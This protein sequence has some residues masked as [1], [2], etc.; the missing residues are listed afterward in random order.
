M[1]SAMQNPT[2]MLRVSRGMWMTIQERSKGTICA[3]IAGLVIVVLTPV[4]LHAQS[5]TVGLFH[6][7]SMASPGY[8][9]FTPGA[10]EDTYLID[11]WGRLINRWE[12]TYQPAFSVYLLE[13]GELLRTGKMTAGGGAGGR[14][15]KFS[16]DG[17]LIWDYQYFTADVLQHHDV[18]PLPNGNVLIL[19]WEDYSQADAIAAGRDPALL[20]PDEL[21]PEHIIEVEPTGLATGNIVWEW[22]LWDHLVQDFDSTKA[23]YGVVAEHPE[24][25]DINYTP[26]MAKDWIHAN[27]IDYNPEL[28]QIVISC[29]VFDEIWVIDHSTT[30]AEAAGHTGGNAGMGGDILYRWGNP[31]TYD[32]GDSTD[33]T[34][35]GQHDARW[36]PSGFAGEGN[37]LIFNNGRG[38]D[39]GDYST[40]D[41]IT[42]TVD[43]NGEYPQP[44]PGVS[45]GPANLTWIYGETPPTDWF[46]TNISGQQRLPNGNTLICSGPDGRFFEVTPDS[47]VVWRY[48]NPAN[49]DGIVIQGNPPGTNRTFR[50]T[51]IPADYPGLAGRDLTPGSAIEIYPIT[52]SGTAHSPLVPMAF[53]SVV[54]TAEVTSDNTITSVELYADLGAGFMAFDMYDDGNHHD[55]VAGD[56]VYGVAIPPTGMATTVPYYVNAQDDIASSVDDPPNPPSTVYWYSTSYAAPQIFI[57][58]VLASNSACCPDE[59]GDFDAWIELYNAE[60]VDVDLSGKYLSND[61]NDTTRF[62]IGDTTIPANGH[63][64]FWADNET[65]EGLAHTTFILNPTAGEIGLFDSDDHGRGVL[66]SLSYSDQTPDTSYGRTTDGSSTWT[67][68]PKPS[69]GSFNGECSCPNHADMNA[70]SFLDA[71]DLN[72][73]IS[74]LF[75]NGSDPQDPQCPAPRSDFDCS[76]ESDAVDL[77]ALINHLFFNG[78]APCDP[79]VE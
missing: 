21:S 49:R 78:N 50:C 13:N 38:R 64:L 57:N 73:I 44:P 46:A 31:V 52:I 41:E 40:V 11:M 45:H 72:A 36:V 6:Y 28:D 51:R 69:P 17:T 5:Q 60:A 1:T 3:L 20:P 10:T 68:F 23:N 16:W 53:D 27:S 48:I 30:T 74:A 14:I 55:G 8:N 56:D 25:V 9:L 32:A 47:Q 18:E 79:C 70:D 63:M 7:D 42:T 12:S 65:V 59:H 61:L 67:V 62:M 22:H 75:F 37:I 33:R 66:D 39:D 71:V 15:Q 19:A 2:G 24:L 29:H 58:E 77:N 35:Y 76:G 54:V 4:L 34:L 26:N 43:V